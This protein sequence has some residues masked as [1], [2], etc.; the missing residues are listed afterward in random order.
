M[1]KQ[2]ILGMLLL[3][4]AA[5]A[6]WVILHEVLSEKELLGCVLVFAAVILTQLPIRAPK[7]LLGARKK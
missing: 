5:L 6:G 3:L 1:K 7:M 4:I 2:N